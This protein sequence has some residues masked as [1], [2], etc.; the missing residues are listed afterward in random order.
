[1]EFFDSPA[2]IGAFLTD[3]VEVLR[4]GLL[5]LERAHVLAYRRRADEAGRVAAHLAVPGQPDPAAY[6]PS[7]EE[8]PLMRQT[9]DGQLLR[10]FIDDSD[11]YDGRPLYRAVVEKAQELGLANAIVLRAPM[12]FGTHRRVRSDRFPDY[13]TELPVLIEIVD[14]AENVGRLLPF[15]DQAVPEGLITVE[16]VKILRWTGDTR[17][18]GGAGVA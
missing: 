9:T 1:M 7:P 13:I 14:T 5:T 12:G 8:F 16:G 6:L 17:P 15:L 2:V 18:G 11:R 10:I 4:E 3:V